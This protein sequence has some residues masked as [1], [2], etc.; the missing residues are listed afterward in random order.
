MSNYDEIK[1]SIDYV[2]TVYNMYNVGY[3]FTILNMKGDK[4]PRKYF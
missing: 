3:P 4:Y 1:K 2:E